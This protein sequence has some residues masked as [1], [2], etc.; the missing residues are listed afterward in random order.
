M[1]NLLASM[2]SIHLIY[3]KMKLKKTKLS[4]EQLQARKTAQKKY[5]RFRN[6]SLSIIGCLIVLMKS[7]KHCWRNGELNT[8][9]VIFHA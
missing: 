7:M 8:P 1:L 3:A 2:Q 6:G 9:H 5:N 4:S